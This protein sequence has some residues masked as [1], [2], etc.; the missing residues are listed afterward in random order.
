[1]VSFIL[2]VGLYIGL[3]TWLHRLVDKT[4]FSLGW[5]FWLGWAISIGMLQIW[6]FFAPINDDS[7][8]VI[9]TIGLAGIILN[10][11]L[12]LHTIFPFT[13]QKFVWILISLIIVA[14]CANRALYSTPDYTAFG[15]DTGF[16]HLPV[17]TWFNQH[18][19]V[20]GLGNVHTRFGFSNAHFL[21]GAWLN[22]EFFGATS[23]ILMN[24]LLYIVFLSQTAWSI[25]TIL[26]SQKPS[27]EHVLR[28]LCLP[29]V[30]MWLFWRSAEGLGIP[31]TSNDVPIFLVGILLTG[32][33]LAHIEK[34][35][36]RLA[37][38]YG[39]TMLVCVGVA[40][41]F[42]FVVLGGGLLLFAIGLFILQKS[43]ILPVL[44]GVSIIGAIIII[45][46]LMRSVIMTGYPLYPL[47]IGG[48]DVD[49]QINRQTALYESEHIQIFARV[50]GDTPMYDTLINNP[51]GDW[52]PFWL[53]KS[54]RDYPVFL[55]TPLV[56]FF[57]G[58]MLL[59]I[60][61]KIRVM[62]LV[63]LDVL[64]VSIIF[65]FISAPLWRL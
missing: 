40:I 33:I 60:T 14:Y 31:S 8:L 51:D 61:K 35:D 16:Y 57:I 64:T 38:V 42:S 22:G 1:M 43:R 65:W 62:H 55:Y 17:M 9:A 53:E 54:S 45:P 6:H 34:R 41:K 2:L 5:A 49:W 20:I 4:R 18:P 23:V 63:F 39:I 28:V 29:F 25:I 10:H 26:T 19:I 15:F 36:I 48:L 7:R 11:R 27:S 32:R 58:V 13:T 37:D 47:T 3:G 46:M 59:I 52:L 21:Y 50:L 44:I 30:L 56:L 12:I 24:T